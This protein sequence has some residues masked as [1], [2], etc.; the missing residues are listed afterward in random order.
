MID[1]RLNLT[2]I[3][4]FLIK[5][6]K[7]S[8][9]RSKSWIWWKS[10]KIQ[11]TLTFSIKFNHFLYIFSINFE[12]FDIIR[13]QFNQFNWADCFG[14]QEFGSKMLIKWP[15][16]SNSSQNLALGWF[17]RHSSLHCQLESE[18]LVIKIS[19]EYCKNAELAKKVLS[20]LFRFLS[21]K[22][23]ELT[24]HVI[25]QILLLCNLIEWWQ[26]NTK[27]IWKSIQGIVIWSC[28]ICKH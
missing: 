16:K 21:W 18:F 25:F 12:I 10:L 28:A 14:F 5:R 7:K 20:F 4:L 22:K 24:N 9:K 2:K 15:F 13:T 26:R 6:S 27:N 23:L 1:F 8:I 3:D 11:Y 19:F 17:N